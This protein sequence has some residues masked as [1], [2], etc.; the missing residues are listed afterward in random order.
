MYRSSAECKTSAVD[1]VIMVG[2]N[3]GSQ[4]RV[5]KMSA[6]FGCVDGSGRFDL[7]NLNIDTEVGVC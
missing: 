6:L 4:Y 1:V 5:Q 7:W 2:Q 3:G